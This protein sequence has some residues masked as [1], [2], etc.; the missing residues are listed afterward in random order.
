MDKRTIEF[1]EREAVNLAA[2]YDACD[3]RLPISVPREDG[4]GE[5]RNRD[6]DDR[7]FNR[8]LPE[9]WQ[10]IFERLGFTLI[11]RWVILKAISAQ[12]N[13]PIREVEANV[14][15]RNIFGESSSP[16]SR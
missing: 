4:L 14:S 11:S 10:L 12:E 16:C 13:A 5:G 2:V 6:S 15:S 1:Y 3:G 7:L 9:K 8:I